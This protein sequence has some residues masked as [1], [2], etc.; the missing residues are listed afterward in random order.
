MNSPDNAVSCHW[1]TPTRL[2]PQ[3]YWLDASVRPWSCLRDG[4][5]RPLSLAELHACATCPRWKARTFDATKRD[6]MFETWGVGIPLPERQTFED[7]RRGLDVG[8]VGRGGRLARVT[9]VI[10][11]SHRCDILRRSSRFMRR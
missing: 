2:M 3:P 5:P 4:C 7:R 1:L 11:L 8:S 9:V 10:A 6:L